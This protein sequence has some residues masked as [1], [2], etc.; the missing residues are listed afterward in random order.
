[1]ASVWS[2]CVAAGIVQHFSR[3]ELL[4]LDGGASFHEE[5]ATV[6]DLNNTMKDGISMTNFKKNGS[7]DWTVRLVNESG[8]RM[9]VSKV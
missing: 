6:D 5:G 3:R 1:V 4:G 2:D 9:V 8:D 7:S